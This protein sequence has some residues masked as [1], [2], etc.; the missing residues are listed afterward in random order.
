[1]SVKPQGLSK[2]FI[3]DR[4]GILPRSTSLSP[5]LLTMKAEFNGTGIRLEVSVQSFH[6]GGHFG[7]VLVLY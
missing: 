6:L 1:M 4:L 7:C 5:I 2:Y 3:C